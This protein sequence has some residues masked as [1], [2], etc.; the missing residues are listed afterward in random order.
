MGSGE[1][2]SIPLSRTSRDSGFS[3]TFTEVKH[4]HTLGLMNAEQLRLFH[5]RVVSN[6]FLHTELIDFL[7]LN[8]G[9][10][11]FSRA[12]IADYKVSDK[13]EMIVYD[14][15]G[16][17]NAQDSGRGLGELMLY[18][19]L[20]EILG[21]PKVLSKI[22]LNQQAG[23]MR[24]RCDAIHLLTPEDGTPVSSIVFGTSSLN[25]DIQ[26]AIDDA[27]EKI[28]HIETNQARECQLA[29]EQVFT[30]VLDEGAARKIKDL[31]IPEPGGTA[32]YDSAYGI[33]LGYDI[34][35]DPVKYSN[36]DYRRQVDLKMADDIKHHAAYITNKITTLNLGTHAFYVYV[37]PFDN[38]LN[39]P[40]AIMATVLQRG[41]GSVV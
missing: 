28:M 15:A 9:R 10:Y 33:F 27:F 30:T 7:R 14:A 12:E 19:L 5:L 1:Q 11:V 16:R 35:L 29:E 4:Q 40:V 26:D 23:H 22:E 34:G 13:S 24:S 21:A 41:G 38:S 39:D 18:I 2:L 17:M 8:L 3:A 31:L 25:G 6:R 36:E 20:E 37:L 32:T